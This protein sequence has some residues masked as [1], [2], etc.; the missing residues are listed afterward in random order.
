MENGDR[1]IHVSAALTDRELTW[2][3]VTKIKNEFLGKDVSA[4]HVIAKE[5]DHVNIHKFCFHIWEPIGATREV[6]NLQNL[7]EEVGI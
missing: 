6:A 3:E 5:S 4:Y 7:V 2:A 1:F